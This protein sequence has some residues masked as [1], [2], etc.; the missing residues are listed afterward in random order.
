MLR[1]GSLELQ[2][3]ALLAPLERVS[4]VGFRALC[5]HLGAAFT[6]TEMTRA[7]SIAKGVGS[8]LELLDTYDEQ[9]AT[10]IQLL[11]KSPRELQ[12]ALERIEVCRNNIV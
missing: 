4:D 1:L 5:F 12:G 8:T 7:S 9:T 10:G 2:S 11:A 3:R 6:W